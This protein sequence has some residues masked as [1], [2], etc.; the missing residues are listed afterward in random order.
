MKSNECK[1]EKGTRDLVEI[2]K[3]SERVAE[4]NGF[5][6]KQTLQL[7]LLCEEIDGMLPNIIDDFEGKLWIEYDDGVCKVKVSVRISELNSSRKND[8]I[9]VAKNKKNA[10]AVGIVGKIRN[11]I[12]NFFLNGASTENFAPSSEMFYLSTGYC[13]GVDYHYLW[14]LDEYRNTVKKEAKIEEWD[15]LEKSVIA[16]VADD[17][18]IGVKGKQA[19]II[20]S[21]RIE[22]ERRELE[23]EAEAEQHRRRAQGE[24]DAIFAR[25]EAQAR[26]MEEI[27]SKQAEG[28]R[29]I[30]EAA[31]GDTNAAIQMMLVE[32]IEELTKI[33]VEAIKNLQIDK[34]TVWDSMSGEGGTPTTANFLSGMMKA[35]PP[36]NE[37]MKMAG[38]Q[39]PEFLGKEITAPEA[40]AE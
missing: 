25:M 23:A 34:I 7:R 14:S 30:V 4:Y 18:I 32:K 9:A 24:A 13:E 28:Y 39:M 19:D 36:I 33:Q 37:T 10:A 27:L 5:T 38:L 26:G 29:K 2:I 15:E 20:I 6:H 31:G 35:I 12:E 8:L 22:K 3:E 17:V 16:S 11:S 40:K 1:I 21:A